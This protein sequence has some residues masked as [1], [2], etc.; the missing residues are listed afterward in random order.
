MAVD[1]G[2]GA[3]CIL[4]I[5]VPPTSSVEKGGVTCPRAPYSQGRQNGKLCKIHELFI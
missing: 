3:G 4:H 2:G 5:N 1:H